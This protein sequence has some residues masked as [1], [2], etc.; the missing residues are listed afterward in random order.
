MERSLEYIS[1]T[2]PVKESI[3]SFH[4]KSCDKI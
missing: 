3:Y 2:V 4:Y 1:N